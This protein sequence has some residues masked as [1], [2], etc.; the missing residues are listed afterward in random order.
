[1]TMTKKEIFFC[2]KTAAAALLSMLALAT[3]SSATKHH[4][5]TPCLP[6]AFHQPFAF[7]SQQSRRDL[8]RNVA[9]STMTGVGI[10][11][12]T[13]SNPSN[14]VTAADSRAVQP[15]SVYQ[16]LPDASSQLSPSIKSLD[17]ANFI[18][19]HVFREKNSAHQ[20]GVLWLGEH[21][22]SARD[23]DLQA[24]FIESIYNQRMQAK[25]RIINKTSNKDS[26]SNTT[27]ME[28]K[29]SI[30]LEQIQIQFQ[31]TLDAFVEGTISEEQMLEETQWSTRWT[32]PYE[33][34]RPVFALAQKL[35]IPLIALN[36]NSEDLAKVEIDGIKG[37][38]KND[39]RRYIKDPIGF[40]NYSR[41]N[42]YKT[43]SAYVI[44]PSYDLHKEMGILKRTIS[45]QVLEN[46]MSF[47]NFFT[48][49]ILWDES[50]AG[51]AY[52]WTKEND[53]G[54]MIGLIG[55]DHV[56]FEKGVVGR[57]QRLMEND[58]S[59]RL[60]KTDKQNSSMETKTVVAS[61][62]L[63]VSVLL[64][65]TLIDSRP[66]G[67]AGAYMYAS[68]S[69]YPDRITLQLRYLKD[70]VSPASVDRELP[71]ST[72]GVLPLANYIVVSNAD[73]V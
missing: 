7:Q 43:Y 5:E 63:N 32:W 51:N 54:L 69:A 13:N 68:S 62:I 47:L 15:F 14:A 45:G 26:S 59:G 21:H 34:Y 41:S 30:G 24:Y 55:A 2:S 46:D 19:K 38:A 17:P 8:I 58:L 66:S 6:N 70:D 27:P 25:R 37:L 53:G 64:N 50:M 10:G 22:N 29:M 42:E 48:G 31:P 52:Q 9:Q 28:H 71:S 36:V 35:K 3:S 16:V 20:G 72:G 61:N 73:T 12:L 57:Y 49:R 1:M 18:Q 11:V 39:I 23:H 56:K 67:S 44:E 60:S 33:N 65:P 4:G 40:A